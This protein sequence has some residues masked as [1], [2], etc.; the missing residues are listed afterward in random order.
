[1]VL[2]QNRNMD[3]GNKTK[4]TEINPHIYGQYLTKDSSILKEKIVSLLNGA[5]K[6]KYLHAKQ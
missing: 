3:Q 1:M 5:G 4:I 6:T 2:A